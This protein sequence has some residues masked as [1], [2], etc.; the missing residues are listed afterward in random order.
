MTTS[1]K[2]AAL[3]RPETLEG[4][5]A[6]IGWPVRCIRG[7]F[8]VNHDNP[9]FHVAE[10]HKGRITGVVIHNGGERHSFHIK[11]ELPARWE[12][13]RADWG[14]PE[15]WRS[16]PGPNWDFDY[17]LCAQC[18]APIIEDDYLCPACRSC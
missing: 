13:G 4:Y 11:W 15:C 2:P 18:D 9:A 3:T 17:V 8:G 7:V 1:V 6:F 5:E 14:Q 12:T 16:G 10:G